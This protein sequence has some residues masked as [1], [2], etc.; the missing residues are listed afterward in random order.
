MRLVHRKGASRAFPPYHSEVPQ[1]YREIGQPVIE[2]GS[3]GTFSYILRGVEGSMDLSLDLHF[4]DQ[5]VFSQ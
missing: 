5:D 4:M 2:G 3:M 1:K